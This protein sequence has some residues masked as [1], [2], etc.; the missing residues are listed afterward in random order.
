MA[1]PILMAGALLLQANEDCQKHFGISLPEAATA[2]VNALAEVVQSVWDEPW[3][4]EFTTGMPS[5]LLGGGSVADDAGTALGHWQWSEE[6]RGDRAPTGDKAFPFEFGQARDDEVNKSVDEDGRALVLHVNYNHNQQQQQQLV[7]GLS[8]DLAWYP[9]LWRTASTQDY[10][11]VHH[12]NQGVG[13]RRRKAARRSTLVYSDPFVQVHEHVCRP[14]ALWTAAT[15]TPRPSSSNNAIGA[16][17]ARETDTRVCFFHQHY[18]SIDVVERDA[19]R[20][21]CKLPCV[22]RL[23]A[24]TC[25]FATP[26]P[27]LLTNSSNDKQLQ[28]SSARAGGRSAYAKQNNYAGDRGYPASNSCSAA[29]RPSADSVRGPEDLPRNHEGEETVLV[30]HHDLFFCSGLQLHEN[31]VWPAGHGLSQTA[32]LSFSSRFLLEATTPVVEAGGQSGFGFSVDVED[33]SVE[34]QVPELHRLHQT[35]TPIRVA[36]ELIADP[37]ILF[38]DEPTSGLDSFSPLQMLINPNAIR[39]DAAAADR[40]NRIRKR[41]IEGEAGSDDPIFGM[42]VG[43]KVAANY[44]SDSPSRSRGCAGINKR[45]EETTAGAAIVPP[46]H[47]SGADF[48]TSTS[49]N[50]VNYTSVLNSTNQHSSQNDLDFA[51]AVQN[52]SAFDVNFTTHNE[53]TPS[54]STRRKNTNPKRIP[55]NYDAII[56]PEG[57]AAGPLGGEV[58]AV[59]A[60]TN[61]SSGAATPRPEILSRNRPVVPQLLG[62]DADEEFLKRTTSTTTS[63]PGDISRAGQ[64]MPRIARGHE[65][66]GED[67]RAQRIL[68][69][70]RFGVHVAGI[71]EDRVVEYIISVAVPVGSALA[72]AFLMFWLLHLLL[73]RCSSWLQ[74][75]RRLQCERNLSLQIAM[76]KWVG[77]LRRDRAL[78]LLDAFVR[79]AQLKL[80]ISSLLKSVRI[81]RA[82]TLREL[83]YRRWLQRTM[84]YMHLVRFAHSRRVTALQM[85]SVVFRQ[86]Q[87]RIKNI[88]AFTG[89]MMAKVVLSRQLR[90]IRAKR[91]RS[92]RIAVAFR[93]VVLTYLFKNYL[94]GLRMRVAEK[95]RRTTIEEGHTAWRTKELMLCVIYCRLSLLR[96]HLLLVRGRRRRMRKQL[97]DIWRAWKLQLLVLARYAVLS[98]RLPSYNLHQLKFHFICKG[99]YLGQEQDQIGKPRSRL[100]LV[101]LGALYRA[102]V[103]SVHLRRL[104]R[105]KRKAR[106]LS[107]FRN[108]QFL[109]QRRK[110]LKQLLHSCFDQ[111]NRHL[112]LP[113]SGA[114]K[115]RKGSSY[116]KV[117]RIAAALVDRHLRR[118]ALSPPVNCRP[119]GRR[120]FV[121]FGAPA[122]GRPA[123]I[124]VLTQSLRI[125]VVITGDCV[126]QAV[127]AKTPAGKRA[128]QQVDEGGLVS[129]IVASHII[130]DATSQLHTGFVL[131][132]FPR[133]IGQARALGAVL[134]KNGDSLTVINLVAANEVLAARMQGTWIHLGSGRLYHKN[135][136]PPKSLTAGPEYMRDDVTG[137]ALVQRPGDTAHEIQ[138]RLVAYNK[139]VTPLLEYYRARQLGGGMEEFHCHSHF[140]LCTK[141]QHWIAKGKMQNGRTIYH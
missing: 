126:R 48:A 39:E 138:A 140:A 139:E 26:E 63:S 87:L 9:L 49:S 123:A 19:P 115:E 117:E 42:G 44:G 24:A 137:E 108:W 13:K 99:L 8:A 2:A 141:I 118:V 37:K 136:A 15:A 114:T 64:R 61:K 98:G 109:Q 77:A 3:S 59:P 110:Q 20:N 50:S 82:T 125:P 7:P 70:A 18:S 73:L 129:D 55:Q 105:Q 122:S 36:L 38:L 134:D 33:D 69:Q 78:R 97:G 131:D 67:A 5:S 103:L 29:A 21:L 100:E 85:R 94:S 68:E 34:V 112:P 74:D 16:G 40:E 56:S 52:A 102:R 53:R 121:V 101:H 89:V 47:P 104:A 12:H 120:V 46:A 81:K 111:M 75:R 84:L 27:L 10:H 92:A 58:E 106:V 31:G 17:Q 96:I 51:L 128:K 135:A 30:V 90:N 71:I 80:K 116:T 1:W 23:H 66:Q 6:A 72:S 79:V 133:S 62:P 83:R 95:T 113:Q 60:G 86:R 43:S 93:R 11:Q 107:A 14:C 130:E 88:A 132:G 32:G 22:V 119:S 124:R 41:R 91:Y 57:Q 35:G 65:S 28:E 4:E 25:P 127:K 54:P 45:N 76:R